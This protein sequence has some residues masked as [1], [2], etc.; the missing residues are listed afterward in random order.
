M[1][2]NIP[3]P[4]KYSDLRLRVVWLPLLLLLILPQC[5]SKHTAIAKL[6]EATRFAGAYQP[7]GVGSFPASAAKV[8][9]WITDLDEQQIRAHAW[10]IWESINTQAADSMPIWENWFSGYEV[11]NAPT[12]LEVRKHGRDYEF[13]SQFFH[14][15]A[16]VSIPKDPAERPVS[17]NRFSPELARYLVSH[18]LTSARVLDSINQSFAPGTPIAAMQVNTSADSVAPNSIAL[19]PVFQF[20]RGDTLTAFPYWAGVS[21]QTTTNFNNPTPDT[22]RQCVVIDPT[23]QHPPGSTVCISCNGEP[24]R[25]W[26]VV[27]LRDFYHIKI[28]K[29]E[30]DSFSVFANTSGDDV[31]RHNNS[32]SASVADLVKAGNYALLVAMHVTS[33]ETIN[34]TWQTFWWSPDTKNPVFGADRPA[35]ISKPWNNYNMR[36]AYYM[37]APAE[38]I[39]NGEP[40]IQFN[41]YLETNLS[42][43]IPGNLLGSNEKITWYGNFS[44]CMSC[45]R[46]AAWGNTVYIPNG[47]INSSDSLFFAAKTKTDF[48]WSIPTRAH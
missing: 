30:A 35:T 39:T 4:Q 1:I 42:G 5:K 12:S 22:W 10:D 6:D 19:K 20:I 21:P 33:K 3:T 26:P 13:P 16:H 32:D 23:G 43:A 47:F 38:A 27:S 31:G 17:F 40:N 24:A 7:P 46:M 41:P 9:K 48:L 45:H 29:A 28:T 25:N 11:F 37:V 18:R 15:S 34:W 8:N 36:T 14:T 44:N 2:K